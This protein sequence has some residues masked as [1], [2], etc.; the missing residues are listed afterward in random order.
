MPFLNVSFIKQS[1]LNLCASTP[2]R[3][4]SGNGYI[5]SKDKIPCFATLVF[6]I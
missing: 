2:F 5:D 6:R 1:M 4:V 3:L